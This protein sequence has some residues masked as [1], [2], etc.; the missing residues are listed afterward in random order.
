[1]KRFRVFVSMA[2]YAI[3]AGLMNLEVYVPING[4]SGFVSDYLSLQRI[5]LFG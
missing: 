1:M 2:H 5:F 4:V 3:L